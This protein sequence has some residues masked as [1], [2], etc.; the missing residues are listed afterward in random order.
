MTRSNL[1]NGHIPIFL[2]VAH[3]LAL[4]LG[5]GTNI[6]SC[7]HILAKLGEENFFAPGRPVSIVIACCEGT[8]ICE[9]SKHLDFF[10]SGSG[11]EEYFITTIMY[12]PL[13][14]M[15]ACSIIESSHT[16]SIPSPVI[17]F[18]EAI[19]DKVLVH[20]IGS[21][22]LSSLHRVWIIPFKKVIP[23]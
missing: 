11:I 18:L 6:S 20:E 3:I 14:V 17:V 7:I 2:P 19:I 8:D 15:L 4:I 13:S 5:D 1:N 22:G 12:L 10:I 21:N 9:G 16:N 23:N